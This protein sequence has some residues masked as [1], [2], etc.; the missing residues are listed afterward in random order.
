MTKMD[1]LMASL[2]SCEASFCL[3]Y[4]PPDHTSL[5]SP[6]RLASNPKSLKYFTIPNLY[7]SIHQDGLQ[8]S[9]TINCY[10]PREIAGLSVMFSPYLVFGVETLLIL[11]FP[12]PG[13][14]SKQSGS[15]FMIK[16]R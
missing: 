3:S 1:L 7:P 11:T 8:L 16:Q 12:N 4:L 9:L 5:L 10:T 13:T 14:K 6:F 15:A 2:S